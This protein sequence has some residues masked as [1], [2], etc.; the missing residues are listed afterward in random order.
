MGFEKKVLTLKARVSDS[1]LPLPD[2]DTATLPPW[3]CRSGGQDH[4]VLP[5]TVLADFRLHNFKE[6]DGLEEALGGD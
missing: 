2:T 6:P 3:S 1:V 5:P 4:R